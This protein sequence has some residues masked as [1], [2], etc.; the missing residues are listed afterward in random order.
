MNN[1]LKQLIRCIPEFKMELH[2]DGY[3]IACLLLINTEK[4]FNALCLLMKK[5][6]FLEANTISRFI[7]EQLC[8]CLAIYNKSFEEI[9]KIEVTKTIKYLKLIQVEFPRIYGVLSINAHFGLKSL[10]RMIEFRKNKKTKIVEM[11]IKDYKRNKDNDILSIYVV[12]VMLL[13]FV[14][15]HIAK[16]KKETSLGKVLGIGNRFFRTLKKKR[17][18]LKI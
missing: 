14:I 17:S 6:Y 3:P 15:E 10:V 13:Y 1:Y 11:R 16:E 5:G 7:V 9:E 4:S 18:Q 2:Q 12:L 8:Y